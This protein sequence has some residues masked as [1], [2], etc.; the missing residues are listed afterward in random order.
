MAVCG[1]W[2]GDSHVTSS[3][4]DARRRLHPDE[5]E[6]LIAEHLTGDI[7]FRQPTRVFARLRARSGRPTWVYQLDWASPLLAPRGAPHSS[8]VALFFANDERVAFTRGYADGHRLSAVMSD[9]LATFIR[10]GDPGWPRW[11]EGSKPVMV[12]DATTRVVN[13]P[14]S[15]IGAA[16]DAIEPE[17]LL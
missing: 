6:E 1:I 3:A 2:G 10:A 5:S 12:F 4:A 11:D 15:A 16:F 13:D 7:I 17:P 14:D 9:A 8:T